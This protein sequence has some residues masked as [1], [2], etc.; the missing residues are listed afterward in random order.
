MDIMFIRGRTG[1]NTTDVTP[2]PIGFAPDNAS[3]NTFSE[4][5]ARRNDPYMSGW[6]V[7]NLGGTNNGLR[8]DVII[9]WFKPLDASLD[10]P[11][12]ADDQLY[13]MIVNGFTGADGTGADYRQRIVVNFFNNVTPSLQTINPD[14]GEVETVPLEIIPNT[15]GRRRLTVELDGGMGRLFK[16]NT[17]HGFLG[18]SAA[19]SGDFNN[20]G[21]VDAADYVAWRKGVGTIYKQEVYNVWRRQVGAMAAS[22]SG[23]TAASTGLIVPEACTCSLAMVALPCCVWAALGLR[24]RF[25]C[26]TT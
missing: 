6:T 8:G 4:W 13:F 14:T 12:I 15:G 22:Q 18:T 24:R 17:G 25:K 19:L 2:I 9:S 20:D 11:A 16:F 7:T 3:P 23:S 10:D 1:P 5:E 26:S 21:E